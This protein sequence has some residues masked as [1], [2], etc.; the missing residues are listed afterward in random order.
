MDLVVG[1]QVLIPWSSDGPPTPLHP[2]YRGPYR[3]SEKRH[4]VMTLDHMHWPLPVDQ[5]ATLSW[6]TAAHV[7]LCDLPFARNP[8]DPSSAQVSLS[9]PTLSIDCVIQHRLLATTTARSHPVHVTSH[10]YLVRFHGSP[11][12]MQLDQGAWRAYSDIAHTMAFDSYA[13]AHPFLT[14]HA[15]IMSMPANWDPYLP[16]PSSRPSHTA[17]PLSERHIP[18][19]EQV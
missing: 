1:D 13:V 17:L 9:T 11:A 12:A 2:L 6:T 4:N 5:P 14:G 3:I 15:P 8:L 19:F 18:S 10:E 7:F 16:P